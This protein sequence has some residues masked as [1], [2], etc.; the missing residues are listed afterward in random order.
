[1]TLNIGHAGVMHEAKLDLMALK[2]AQEWEF[3]GREGIFWGLSRAHLFRN[4][5][6]YLSRPLL[7]DHILIVYESLSLKLSNAPLLAIL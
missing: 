5:Q 2:M 6:D 3:V 7:R 1:M 4:H